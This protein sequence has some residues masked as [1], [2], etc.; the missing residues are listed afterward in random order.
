M[1]RRSGKDHDDEDCNEAEAHR[2]KTRK[3]AR[4]REDELRDVHL[5]DQRSVLQDR[6]HRHVRR[7]VEECPQGL[8]ADQIQRIVVDLEAEHVREYHRHHRHH[9]ERIEQTPQIAQHAAAVFDLQVT[10][11][12]FL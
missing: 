11:D 5:L 9:H 4:N 6:I 7:L 3:D 2:D 1:Q 12:E 8:T 10:S